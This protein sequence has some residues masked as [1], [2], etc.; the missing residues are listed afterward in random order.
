MRVRASPFLTGVSTTC[1]R[2]SKLFVVV[3]VE[4]Q[5]FLQL[6]RVV[7]VAQSVSAFGC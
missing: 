1:L 6:G 3:A 2:F 5:Y 7:S 4:V